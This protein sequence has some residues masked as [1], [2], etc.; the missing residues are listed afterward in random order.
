MIRITISLLILLFFSNSL[1]AQ[2]SKKQAP[3]SFYEKNVNSN[4]GLIEISPIDVSRLLA[5]DEKEKD[6]P[7]RFGKDIDVSLSLLNAGTWTTLPNGDRIWRLKISSKHAYS[8]NL[9]YDSFF[10]PKGGTFHLYNEAKNHVIGAFTNENN[11]QD[12][13][14]ATGVVKGDVCILEYFEPFNQLGK[15]I[16]SISKV[17]HAYKDIFNQANKIFGASGAC[18][19]NV[20][21]GV[22]DDWQDEKKSVAMVLTS[23]NTRI[24]TGALVNNVNEDNTPYFFNC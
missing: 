1:F 2:I 7:W 22:G 19:N 8:I 9:I 12:G 4:I 5:E 6:R 3:R 23:A 17:I 24:C 15:G 14:F 18:N 10:L 13:K 11:K 21:C 16:I 20:N